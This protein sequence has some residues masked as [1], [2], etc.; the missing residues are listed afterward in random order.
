[1]LIIQYKCYRTMTK[2]TDT[3][4]HL[5][6]RRDKR[7][8]VWNEQDREIPL[9]QHLVRRVGHYLQT[10]AALIMSWIFSTRMS[11]F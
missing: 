3:D 9:Q 5:T 11:S 10:D 1:M 4:S 8:K 6:S 7:E 2:S